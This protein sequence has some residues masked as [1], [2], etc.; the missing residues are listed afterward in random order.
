M[1]GIIKEVFIALSC[2]SGSLADVV[3]I[4]YYTNCISLN[5]LS[6][7]FKSTLTDSNTNKHF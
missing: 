1:P 6:G 7:M 5:N 3:K 4:P 2:F